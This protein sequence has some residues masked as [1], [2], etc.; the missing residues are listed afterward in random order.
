[1]A[2]RCAGTKERRRRGVFQNTILY[3]IPGPMVEQGTWAAMADPGTPAAM[4]GQGNPAAM[5]GQGSPAA[6]ADQGNPVRWVMGDFGHGYIAPPKK[7]KYWGS[8]SQGDFREPHAL[9]GTLAVPTLG[10]ARAA[11]TLWAPGPKG[12]LWVPGPEWTPWAPGPEQ[13]A[14]D[15]FW[16]GLGLSP[17]T[18]GSLPSN[19]VLWCLRGPRGNGN[20]PSDIS[21]RPRLLV[22]R[23]VRAICPSRA[24]PYLH[25]LDALN[26]QWLSKRL[27][28]CTLW[29][30]F[31]SSRPKCS[32]VRKAVWMQLHSGT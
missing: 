11:Q 12:I 8:H 3:P 6:M 19:S 31:R 18:R 14:V 21:V 25:S 7:K 32:P 10:G 5:A 23:R 15:W 27:R 1:M 30:C 13:T 20:L 29:L 22:G 16:I 17:D 26:A 4:A 2:G 28:R 24:E 9:W